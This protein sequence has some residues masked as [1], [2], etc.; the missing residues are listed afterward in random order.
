MAIRQIRCIGLATLALAA[1]ASSMVTA[2]GQNTLRAP[3]GGDNP[4][5]PPPHCLDRVEAQFSAWPPTVLA[6]Q[7]TTLTWSVGSGGSCS[8]TLSL[9]GEPVGRSGT[10]LTTVLATT[11]YQLTAHGSGRSK[12]WFAPVRVGLPPRDQYGR[13]DVT[14]TSNNQA[15]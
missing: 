14:I 2:A 15:W 7:T 3:G 9:H 11:T 6:G 13:I 5:E 4:P 10:R 1:A 8:Y 12:T